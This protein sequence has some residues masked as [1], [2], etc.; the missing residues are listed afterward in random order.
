MYGVI[1]TRH[2]PQHTKLI[3]IA[4]FRLTKMIGHIMLTIVS[5]TTV[6][7]ESTLFE[8]DTIITIDEYT[9]KLFTLRD[10][11]LLITD[12]RIALTS[13]PEGSECQ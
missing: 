6:L 8:H 1:I 7:A 9:Q 2:F 5:G 13:C 3:P 10:A 11:S 4:I 12:D